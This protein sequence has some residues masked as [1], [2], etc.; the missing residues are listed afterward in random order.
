MSVEQNTLS[1]I[2]KSVNTFYVSLL[3][4]VPA[5]LVCSNVDSQV[6]P[7]SSIRISTPAPPAPNQHHPEPD[8]NQ[9][10]ST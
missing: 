7:I 10:R 3:V 9:N 4:L 6:L 2:R 5:M 1:G 8:A